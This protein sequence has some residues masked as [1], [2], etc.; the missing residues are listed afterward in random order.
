[1]RRNTLVA[2]TLGVTALSILTTT[3]G[4]THVRPKG[5]TPLRVSLAPAYNACTA[6]NRTHG[7]PLAFPSCSPPTQ[8]SGFLTVGTP[9]TNG[10]AA[11]SVGFFTF[12]VNPASPDNL[13]IAAE[14]SDVRCKPGS[15]VTTC[16]NANTS[17]GADYTGEI[18]VNMNTRITDHFNGVS[19]GGGTDAATIVDLPAPVTISCGQTADPSTGSVCK[20]V[21]G[22]CPPSGCSSVRNGDRTLVELGQVYVLDGGPD[23]QVSSSGNTVF[24]RQGL[25]IP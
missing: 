22:L 20:F 24:A 9:D 4:A 1:M 5:A 16:G 7:P 3:A 21:R 8:S 25:F 13:V 6:P 11:N 14:I 2:F 18:Q 23:G 19:P 15:G 17:G 10:A 12:S